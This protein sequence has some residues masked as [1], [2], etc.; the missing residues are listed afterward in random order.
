LRSARLDTGTTDSPLEASEFVVTLE[1][2]QKLK[3]RR[4]EKSRCR[5]SNMS[6]RA[7]L[8]RVREL[9]KGSYADYVWHIA[10]NLR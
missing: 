9:G 5:S 3:I 7:K 8:S 2:R 6:H 1:H 10:K 4:S